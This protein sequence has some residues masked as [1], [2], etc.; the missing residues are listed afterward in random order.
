MR[1]GCL[2]GRS[3]TDRSCMPEIVRLLATLGATAELL[4]LGDH[5]IDVA[6]VCLDYDLY[7]LKDKSDLAMSVA[8]DLHAAGAALLNPYPV[9]ALLRDRIVT[10][11][12]LRAAG[13]PVPETFVASHASQLL[14]ALD[15]GPLIIKPSRRSPKQRAHV[16]T[17]AAELAELEPWDEPVFAQRY[18]PP[19]G[20]DR[21]IY[22]IGRE[23]FGVLRDR[24]A[25]PSHKSGGPCSLSPELVEIAR[26]CE[27]TLG[28]DLYGVDVVESD[29]TAYVVGI[30]SF[31]S[32]K[33]VP[34]APRRV[35]RYI[36]EAAGRAARG[37]PIIAPESLAQR[38]MG[39]PGA[40]KGSAV[41]L[42]LRALS[43]TPATPEELDQ[44]QKLLDATRLRTEA[45]AL[46]APPRPGKARVTAGGRVAIYSQDSLGLG[47][48]RRNTVIGRALLEATADS[49]LLLFAD[50]PVAPFFPV[51]ERMDH[52]KL[53]SIR[54]VTAGCWEATRLPIDERE[55]IRL[56]SNVLCDALLNFRP[57]LVL[58]DHMPGGARAELIPAL[59]A[60]KQAHP[61]ALVVLGLRDILD[62]PDVIKRVWEQEGAYE[63]LCRYYDAILIYGSS[64]I[65]QTHQVYQLPALP[66]GTHYC[67]YV[68]ERGAVESANEIRQ[69]IALGR[70][71][72]VFVSAGGGGDGGALMR[73]Y[74]DAIRLLGARARFGTLMAV[75]ANAPPQLVGELEAKARGL[76]VRIVPYVQH[77]RSHMAAA[78][79]VVCMAGYNTLS[80]VLYLMKKA[81]VVP[82]AGPSAEQ[83]MRAG[84]F[85]ERGLIDVLDP[86]ALSPESLAQRLVQDLERT[87]YPMDG[88]GVPLDGASQAAGW[89]LEL[90]RDESH[91][92][93]HV[94]TK[95]V[96]IVSGQ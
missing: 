77:S 64:E 6:R 81:L 14:P 94:R 50:S 18:Y 93:Q 21:R 9:T 12:V 34:D 56:R 79:L 71:R 11:R 4:H 15:R 19:D 8:A 60:L 80:E 75:G 3:F 88:K 25:G 87:D 55:L 86:T 74:V 89:L 42:V 2:M 26:C 7:V 62:A 90:L 67:G 63:A 31:P 33:G 96:R 68:V 58:V 35:A 85:A 22:S 41:A 54:K 46:S 39:A 65:F 72:V 17:N 13:L 32:F 45:A 52:V 59:Q 36:Y 95:R 24:S 84:I 53:P 92:E 69:E 27:A 47:H 91:K 1:I 10:S 82:R 70:R 23:L 51:P 44:I 5:L 78:D 28:V 76:P 83:R 37:E 38:P 30:S 40:L 29:G 66:H 57:D 16:V 49:A 43:T 48:L 61:H 73:T 20:P